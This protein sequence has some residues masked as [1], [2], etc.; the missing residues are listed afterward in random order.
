MTGTNLTVVTQELKHRLP[1][2]QQILPPQVQPERLMRT[3]LISIERNPKL[4]DCSLPSIV[5]AATTAAVLGLECDGVTGQGYIIPY[6]RVATFQMGY[7]GMNTLAARSGYTINA[8]VVREGDL[9]EYELGSDAY[10]KHRPQSAAGR[11]VAAWATATSKGRTPIVDVMFIEEIYAIKE[12]SQGAKKPDS[13]WNDERGPGFAAMCEKTVRRRLF[14]SMPLSIAQKAAALESEQEKGN[15]AWLDE[16]GDVRTV[17]EGRVEGPR[18]IDVPTEDILS[19][20]HKPEFPEK[21]HSV[22]AWANWSIDECLPKLGADQ[23][24]KWHGF[25]TGYMAR[26]RALAEKDDGAKATLDDLLRVYG[27]RIAEGRR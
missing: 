9:F 24:R 23:A 11:I 21:F 2:F 22:S 8:K 20:A 5:N 6:G 7:K 13:P 16:K 1:M 26:L 25:Y 4:L 27:E 15:A 12:R 10:V 14:R 3:V 18:I 17:G 19:P